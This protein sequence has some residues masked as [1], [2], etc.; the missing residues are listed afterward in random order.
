LFKQNIF[1]GLMAFSLVIGFAI[2]TT[3][4]GADGNEYDCEITNNELYITLSKQNNYFLL[5]AYL[6]MVLPISA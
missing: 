4:V 2:S 6:C 3:S 5:K 1:K